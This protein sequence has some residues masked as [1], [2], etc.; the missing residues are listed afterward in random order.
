ML[1]APTRKAMILLS[2]LLVGGIMSS[3]RSGVQWHAERLMGIPVSVGLNVVRGTEALRVRR[4][5]LFLEARYFNEEDLKALF[6]GL[7]AEYNQPEFLFADAY[8]DKEEGERAIHMHLSPSIIDVGPSRQQE[9]SPLTDSTPSGKIGSV[10]ADYFRRQGEEVFRY[11]IDL[12]TV[13]YRTVTINPKTV[14]YVG[15]PRT[16]LILA[17]EAGDTS[18]LRSILNTD[19]NRIDDNTRSTAALRA[20]SHGHNEIVQILLSHG[21][22]LKAVTERQWTLLMIEAAH[23]NLGIVQTLLSIGADV[24]V[25]DPN[26]NS[27]LS[28]AVYNEHPEI[29]KL[30]LGNGAIADTQDKDGVTPLMMAAANGD[31]RVVKELLGMGAKTELKSHKGK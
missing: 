29:A 19:A 23:G 15:N 30:L 5:V 6:S 13:E 14:P 22:D 8:A 24:N 21:I 16:D 18:R 20:S 27:A 2:A 10:R 9:E 7:A 25:K 28:L 26:G 4:V 12:A 11:V 31:S 17:A 3:D 1:S